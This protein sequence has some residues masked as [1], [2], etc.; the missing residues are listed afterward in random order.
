MYQFCFLCSCAKQYR[1]TYESRQSRIST[2]KEMKKS[3]LDIS[4]H[5]PII[6]ENCSILCPPPPKAGT[7]CWQKSSPYC[8]GTSAIPERSSPLVAPLLLAWRLPQKSKAR[9]RSK[10]AKT[11]LL[12]SLVIVPLTSSLGRKASV[13]ILKETSSLGGRDTQTRRS[14]A[15]EGA[16]DW[17]SNDLFKEGVRRPTAT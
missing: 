2:Q 16:C 14:R 5:S 1:C 13:Y 11:Q 15:S 6:P 3:F 9:R 12:Q 4:R 10:R 7:H 17:A 8:K